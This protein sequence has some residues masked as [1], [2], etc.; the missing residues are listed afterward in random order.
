[1]NI[2]ITGSRSTSP[3]MLDKA[4]QVVDWCIANN[5]SVI[6]GDA[7]GIDSEVRRYCH[8]KHAT[9]DV[10]GAYQRFKYPAIGGTMICCDF[11]NYLARDRHMVS[12]CDMCVAVWNGI[13]GGTYYT[14]THARKMGKRVIIRRFAV[15][16][17]HVID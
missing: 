6:V 8:Q 5:H 13:T 16:L 12:L 4:R 10:F 7:E 2:L 3:L 14:F 15:N 1:M 17:T 9:C 11:P